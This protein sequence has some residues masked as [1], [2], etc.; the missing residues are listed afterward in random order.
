MASVNDKITDTRNAA[1]PVSTT[2]SGS[3]SAGG[4]TLSCASLTGWPTAS[5]V[6]FVTYQIDS[7]SNPITGTQLDC[8]GI[9][10]GSNIGSL[11]VV[12]GTDT[13]NS[14]GDIVEMLPTSA[15]G[16][17]LADALTAEHSRLGAHTTITATAL[18]ATGNVQA[19][20]ALV[21]DTVSEKT[22]ANGVS[23]DGLNIK[24]SKLNTNNSVVTANITADAVVD[25]KLIYGKVRSRQGGSA[26]DW[27]SVGANT[28]D[29]SGTDVFVQVGAAVGTGGAYKTITFPTAFSQPP[30]VICGVTSSTGFNTFV[31]A[32][33]ITATT[34]DF[35]CF[36][37]GA[38][39]RAENINWIAIGQ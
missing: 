15:W 4:T 38:T 36:D 9:V 26:T 21:A 11:V 27:S 17:D 3:R 5:K 8:Y 16:Q 2:V 10:S 22:A 37:T 18:T 19:N 29:Y 14:I 7:N 20:T 13:G 1:R 23:V 33:N 28:Y 32:R 6:H 24:D 30:V 31:I 39:A 25:S 12:D 34:F 35:A